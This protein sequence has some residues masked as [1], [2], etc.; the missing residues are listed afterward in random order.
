MW[1]EMQT[2]NYPDQVYTYRHPSQDPINWNYNSGG[3]D[4]NNPNF[5]PRTAVGIFGVSI[6][7]LDQLKA[8]DEYLIK[9]KKSFIVQP[10]STNVNIPIPTTISPK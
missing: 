1:H 9:A 3:N 8:W 5:D 10:S 6:V 4:P 7:V 2:S